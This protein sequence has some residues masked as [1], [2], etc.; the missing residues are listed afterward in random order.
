MKQ[1][2]QCVPARYILAIMGFCAISLQFTM[3]ANL[4]VAIVAMV[5]TEENANEEKILLMESN[6]TAPEG[7]CPGGGDTEDSQSQEGE[8]AWDATMQ[9]Y[10]LSSYYYGYVAMQLPGGYLAERYGGRYVCGPGVFLSGVA[11]LLSPLAARADVYLFMA[12]RVLAGAASGVV[13]PSLQAM[14]SKWFHPKERSKFS[15]FL[16]SGIYAGS[17]IAMAV[18]GVLVEAGG[19][20]MAF[21]FFGAVAVAWFV[22]WLYL[23][24]STPDDHPRISLQ[25]KEYIKAGFGQQVNDKQEKLPVPWMKILTSAPVW[26]GIVFHSGT[27]WVLY[28]ML[29]DLPTYL[30][31]ILHFGVQDSGLISSL[32]YLFSWISGV[33]FG[34]LSQTLRAK[35]I[36][37][38]LTCYRLFNGITSLGA[39]ACLVAITLVGCQ[40]QAIVVLLVLVLVANSGLYGG[41][42]LNHVDLARNFAGTIAGILHLLMN[43]TGIFTPLVIGALTKGNQTLAQ[44]NI[45]FYIAAGVTCGCFVFYLIFGSVE[46]QSWNRLPEKSKDPEKSSP[47]QET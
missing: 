22:P 29:S 6:S 24:Y 41:S 27:A 15:G 40:T 42:Y 36:L 44:W 43:S 11:T 34:W 23:I 7:T 37:S 12:V 25:E 16:F 32:T 45:A 17:L 38:H 26:A 9:G 18:S 30:K 28:T 4:S 47:V 46:E 5:K 20:P 35:G 33:A 21:Y 10:V 14:V 2:F 3:K 39:A 13:I 31:F 8:F 1:I 19:W